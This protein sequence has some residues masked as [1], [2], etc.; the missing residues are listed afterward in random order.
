MD[1]AQF[2]DFYQTLEVPKD[3]PHSEILNRKK[4]LLE[5]FAVSQQG[6]Q[7]QELKV[8]QECLSL[9]KRL[10]GILTNPQRRL[11]YDMAKGSV[12]Y[13]VVK[14]AATMYNVDLT[15]FREFWR[16]KYAKRVKDAKGHYEQAKAAKKTGDMATY[17][18]E[19]GQARLLDPFSYLD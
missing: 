7:P 1:R 6:F 17:D 18:K 9:I 13:S 5:V 4:E 3:A 16:N 15:P 2:M 11:G 19:L 10:T 12:L 8:L 14:E